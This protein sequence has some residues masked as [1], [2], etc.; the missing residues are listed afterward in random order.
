MRAIAPPELQADIITWKS[1]VP[2][3]IDQWSLS[4][5]KLSVALELVQEQLAAGHIEHSRPFG[6][7]PYLSYRK[8]QENGAY[9]KTYV[10]STKLWFLRGHYNLACHPPLPFLRIILKLL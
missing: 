8:D 3:Q 4:S 10:S 9:Y 1:D 7:H 5:P 2:V 6:I